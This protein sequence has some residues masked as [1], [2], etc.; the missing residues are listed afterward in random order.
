LGFFREKKIKKRMPARVVNEGE[1]IASF[2]SRPEAPRGGK[3]VPAKLKTH[4]PLHSQSATGGKSM[5][6]PSFAKIG[7][8]G[9][10]GKRQVP[11]SSTGPPAGI[12][13]GKLPP[14]I[15]KGGKKHAPPA[16]GVGKPRIQEGIKKK[17]RF[18]PGT[19]ALREIRRYQ[20]STEL[21]LRKLPFQRLAREVC[22]E[23]TGIGQDK[24]WQSAAVIALQEAAEA[25]LI[26]LYEDTNLNAIHAKRITIMPKDMQLARRIRGERM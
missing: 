26:H 18:K 2:A 11:T 13:A 16:H 3:K 6:L 20:K 24:R 12:S 10:G 14:V 25:Y 8:G 19:V 21:L 23:I 22:N 17:R 15:S 9:K 7:G 1:S 4:H 5:R